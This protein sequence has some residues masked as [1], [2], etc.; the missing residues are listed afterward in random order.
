MQ[1]NAQEN[2]YLSVFQH[3][4]YNVISDYQTLNMSICSLRFDSLTLFVL[5][6]PPKGAGRSLR[7]CG[8]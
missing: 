3:S 8:A 6:H 1:I 2:V 7:L 4:Y 5:A